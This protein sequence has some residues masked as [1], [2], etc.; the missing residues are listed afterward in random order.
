MATRKRPRSGWHIWVHPN[1]IG[2]GLMDGTDPR[3]QF[4]VVSEFR[5]GQ[6]DQM[7]VEHAEAAAVLLFDA[8]DVGEVTPSRDANGV[9][10][11][12]LVSYIEGPY[13]P[14]LLIAMALDEKRLMRMLR[15]GLDVVI[16]HRGLVTVPAPLEA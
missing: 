4:T 2:M 14:N 5:R 8:A 10:F 11:Q 13:H 3:V 1:L 16:P 15:R 9:V 12:A 6:T 7:D